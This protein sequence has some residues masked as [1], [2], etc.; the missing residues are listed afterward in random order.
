MAKNKNLIKKTIKQYINE[1]E[2]LI[3]VEKAILFGSWIKGTADE[4]SDIDLAI[5][6]PDFGKHRLKEAQLLSRAAWNVDNTIEAIPYSTAELNCADPTSFLCLILKEG[7][8]V[9]SKSKQ[10]IT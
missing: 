1:L 2:K 9:Y 8:V 7:E 6:S 5:F 10:E 3:I 4:Y